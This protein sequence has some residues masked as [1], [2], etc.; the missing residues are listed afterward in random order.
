MISVNNKH[1]SDVIIAFPYTHRYSTVITRGMSKR[2]GALAHVV[3]VYMSRFRS[4][5]HHMGV[6]YETYFLFCL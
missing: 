5:V 3:I 1:K 4:T 6:F 2:H